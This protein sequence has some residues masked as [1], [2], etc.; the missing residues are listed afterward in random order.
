MS[1]IRDHR[2]MN[3]WHDMLM[4]VVGGLAIDVIIQY[5]QGS[6]DIGWNIPRAPAQSDRPARS[7]SSTVRLLA[8]LANAGRFANRLYVYLIDRRSSLVDHHQ[9][10]YREDRNVRCRR[11]SGTI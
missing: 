2:R 1:D 5:L 11:Q 8:E 9:S 7:S 6:F 3:H 4:A 10:S